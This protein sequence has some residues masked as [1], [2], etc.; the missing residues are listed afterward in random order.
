M[1]RKT[2]DGLPRKPLPGR[3]N[4]VITRQR[5]WQ[6]EGVDVAASVAEALK[7]AGDVP[8]IC[9]IGGGEIYQA[10]LSLADRIY[11]TEV[12]VTVEG[13]VK[14]PMLDA[15]AWRETACHEYDKAEKDSAAFTMRVLDRIR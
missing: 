15:S 12:D 13:D 8:E 1:G 11:L 14:A 6:A 3:K 10:F 2:W 9:V 5:G 4:I 7:L